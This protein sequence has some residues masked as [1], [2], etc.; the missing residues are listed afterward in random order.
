MSPTSEVVVITGATAGVGR[1]TALLFAER[2]AAVALLSRGEDALAETAKEV[3][4]AGGTALEVP[5]DVADPAQVDEA[6]MRVVEALG[7]IDVWVNN[8]M[9]SVFAPF[10]E[11]EPEE[12]RR[13]TDVTYH[14]FVNGTR[15]ALRHMTPRD[16]GTIVQVG[17]ALAYR[18]IPLQTAY[19]GAKHAVQGFTE[20]L[21]SELYSQGSHIR[22]GMVQLPA[23]NTPQFDWV[24]SRLPGRPQPVP[25][26]F[27]PEVA[28]R[29]VVHMADHPRREIWVGWPSVRT[30]LAN[31]LAPGALDLYLGWKGLAAQ[32][33]DEPVAE[34]RPSNLWEP[35]RRFHTTRGSFS[36]RALDRS[37]MSWL[38]L[39]RPTLR[40]A[41]E[42]LA[43]RIAAAPS[44]R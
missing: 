1:A 12:F 22:I 17:S 21:R 36:D 41:R 8:A 23:V 9:T 20:S 28:A 42:L 26:I 37:A 30:I 16:S 7:P 19:C 6:A 34:D 31:K 40:W 38:S 13:V 2:G 43:A 25:P 29:A 27:Q 11:I 39:H 24:L 14:G 44:E 4:A 33:T 3:E 15:A 32:Q 35:A 18:G 10:T 5:T